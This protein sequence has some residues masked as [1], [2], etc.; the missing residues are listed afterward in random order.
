VRE[1]VDMEFRNKLEVVLEPVVV[2]LR[3]KL[4]VLPTLAVLNHYQLQIDLVQTDKSIVPD[5]FISKWRYLWAILLSQPYREGAT[6]TE[7]VFEEIDELVE[8]IFQVYEI[9]AIYEPG[10]FPRSEREFLTRLGL[11]IRVREPDVLGFP[12]Q[13][14]KWAALRF[15]PFDETY[16]LPTFAS[17][18]NQLYSWLP[19]SANRVM[20]K[21]FERDILSSHKLRDRYLRNR[22]RETE[23]WVAACL[24]TPF[25]D[26]L[27]YPN[28]YID[29]GG[30]E[31]DL[32][33]HAGDTIILVE[34]K[35]SKIRAFEGTS[36]DL[37]K[38]E[39]DFENSIQFGF[40]QAL[41]VKRRILEAEE[42]TF[43]DEKGREWFTIK[44]GKVKKLYI[45]CI[46]ATPR[47][48][49]GTDLSYELSKPADEPFPLA[50]RLFDFDLICKHLNGPGQ[51]VSYLLER[52]GLHGHVRTGDELNFAG[53]FLKYG[54][55]NFA[56]GTMVADDFSSIFDRTWFREQGVEVEEP[57]GPPVTTALAREGNRLTITQADGRKQTSR[58]PP[59]WIEGASGRPP[60]RM[61]GSQ[62]NNPCPCGSGRKFKHCHGL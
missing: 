2:E 16:F 8:K 29:K 62:R 3:Q 28:Y 34:C 14:R 26:A 45:V 41:E 54:N 38:F 60:L 50:L 27:V 20:A 52:E 21:S 59:R 5:G 24:K 44:R 1:N 35:N 33:V 12:E 43:F 13:I 10:R 39:S 19:A 55:L 17:Q 40:E 56:D 22:D 25:P 46:T 9:G 58:V 57:T 61:K 11:A 30:H 48:L 42:T 47:G 15:Q 23:R 51:F 49:F 37:L 53:Y 36:A 6:C 7:S 4:A 32:L 31:K 18:F